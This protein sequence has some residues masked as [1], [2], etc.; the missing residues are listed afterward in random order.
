MMTRKTSMGL[1][2]GGWILAAA[3]GGCSSGGGKPEFVHRPMVTQSA[4]EAVMASEDPSSAAFFDE[5]ERVPLASQD[6][7]VHAALLL[8]TGTSQP[9]WPMRERAAQQLGLLPTDFARAGREAV[10]V[11]EVSQMF[12]KILTGKRAASEDAAVGIMV[13][14]G[15]LPET[16]LAAQGLTGAQLLSMLGVTQDVMLVA[17]VRKVTMPKIDG[18]SS[19]VQESTPVVTTEDSHPLPVLGG[20]TDDRPRVATPEPVILNTEAVP[21]GKVSMAAPAQAPVQT[22]MVNGIP[23]QTVSVRTSPA[24]ELTDSTS[25]PAIIGPAGVVGGR[26]PAVA[27]VAPAV[28]EAKPVVVVAAPV[29]APQAAPQPVAPAEEA[30]VTGQKLKKKG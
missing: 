29:P 17:G 11:G 14:R 19:A 7:A 25:K 16:R 4:P 1:A 24:V 10:T 2:V 28:E 20:I 12:S 5:L 8:A 3:M 9:T 27:P 18:S 23:A 26:A 21:L 13:E 22:P 6:D 30:W 15:I